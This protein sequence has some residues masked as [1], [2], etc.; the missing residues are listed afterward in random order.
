LPYYLNTFGFH[1][2]HGKALPIATGLQA[3]RPDLS[4]WVVA[5]DGDTLG[6]G[7]GH[8]LHAARRNANLKILLLNN[9]VFGLHK[10]HHS[11]TSRLGTRTRSSP[12]GSIESPIRPLA[13]ALAAGVTFAARGID[14]DVEHLAMILRAAAGHRGTAFVEVLQNCKIFND[15]AFD[16]ATD[17]TVK[18]DQT[19]YLEHGRPVIF[20]KDRQQGIRLD[21]LNPTVVTMTGK[22]LPDL[23]VHDEAAS[24]P[25]LAQLL[26]SLAFPDFPES[27]GIFRRVERPTFDELLAEPEED[28]PRPRKP[29]PLAKLLAGDDPWIVD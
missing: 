27:F 16:F 12:R 24:S 2:V 18:A 23:L 20:G 14:V 8:L 19:I 9:E 28:L 29:I 15:G 7:A 22:K 17:K 1:T 13:V 4:V 21:G 11:P 3:A 10:G 6:P 26:A 25:L 5:G